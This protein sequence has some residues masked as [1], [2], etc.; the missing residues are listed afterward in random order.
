MDFIYLWVCGSIRLSPSVHLYGRTRVGLETARPV[1]WP[2]MTGLW[3]Q[4]KW[5]RGSGTRIKQKI[6]PTDFSR[7]KAYCI[8]FNRLQRE[9]YRQKDHTIPVVAGIFPGV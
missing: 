1:L 8:F 7:Q 2:L 4:G 9:K 5:E 3:V 6:L